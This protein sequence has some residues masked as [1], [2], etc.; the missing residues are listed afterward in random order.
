MKRTALAVILALC[1]S[2]V[3]AHNCP[4]EMKAIDAALPKAKLD[5]AKASEVK[6]LRADGEK[7]HKDGKHTESMAALGKAKGILGIK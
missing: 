7:L 3:F 5:A 4:N 6:K 2:P 1:A